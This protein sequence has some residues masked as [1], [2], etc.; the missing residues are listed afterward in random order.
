[1]QKGGTAVS[2]EILKA[3]EPWQ[4]ALSTRAGTD[5]LAHAVRLLLESNPDLVLV[6]LDGVGAFDHIRRA[7]FLP[8]LYQL[9]GYCCRW[10]LP[11]MVA[12]LVL[13]GGMQKDVTT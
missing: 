9:F 12:L 6:S 2:G 10:L 5:A 7:R 1:M 4:F 13:Y 3:T 8:Q 11:S